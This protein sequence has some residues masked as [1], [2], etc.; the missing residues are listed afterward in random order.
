MLREFELE[1]HT[2]AT[3]KRIGPKRPDPR[4]LFVKP[5][6]L[7][8]PF[9]PRPKKSKQQALDEYKIAKERITRECNLEVALIFYEI[10][11]G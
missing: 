1:M 2:K 8:P 9:T 10:Y 4:L 6:P 5:I 3:E 7:R 11:S